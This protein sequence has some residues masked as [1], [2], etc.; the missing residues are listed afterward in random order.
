MTI[1]L[2]VEKA[3]KKIALLKEHL[4]MTSDPQQRKGIIEKINRL[5][6]IFT[7]EPK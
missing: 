7:T 3:K 1:Q 4:K 5:H 6:N 2:G